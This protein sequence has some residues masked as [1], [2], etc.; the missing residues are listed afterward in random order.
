[1]KKLDYERFIWICQQLDLK[2]HRVSR[3]S[4]FTLSKRGK[5][6]KAAGKKYFALKIEK[7][8]ALKEKLKKEKVEFDKYKIETLNQIEKDLKELNLTIDDVYNPNNVS[9]Q[10]REKKVE[11]KFVG[12]VWY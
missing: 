1:M 5:R 3:Y 7:L 8:V 6:K 9:K 2:Y 10:V 12:R 11:T 4:Y